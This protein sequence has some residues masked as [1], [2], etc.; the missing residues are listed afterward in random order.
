MRSWVRPL[1]IL[2]LLGVA[3]LPAWSII[4]ET[5]DGQFHKGR[6]ISQDATRIVLKE[7]GRKDNVT[8]NRSDIVRIVEIVQAKHLMT[9]EP[10]NPQAYFDY[11]GELSAQRDDPEALDMALRLYLISAYL[12]PEK[13]GFQALDKMSRIARNEEEGRS[14][15]AMAFLLDRLGD[16]RTLETQGRKVKKDGSTISSESVDDFLKAIE[17][18]RRGKTRE[19]LA[20]GQK[21]GVAEFFDIIPDL[22][23][24]KEF[25]KL[26]E[27]KPECTACKNGR[28]ICKACEAGPKQRTCKVCNA[29]GW[30]LCPVCKGEPRRVPVT[31]KQFNI[32]LRLELLHAQNPK[33]KLEVTTPQGSAPEGWSR[34]LAPKHMQPVPVL[35]LRYLTEFDPRLCVYVDGRWQAPTK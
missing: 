31:A 24:Y 18:L 16:K 34:L 1:L 35:S 30:V 9:L 13:L 32:I 28:L 19:A 25:V 23:S 15:R 6:M 11:A 21:E 20:Q 10:K 27:K 14:F 26:C 22:M 8:I 3:P 5:K 12:Q 7:P 17:L 4:I 2:V 29:K 33:A